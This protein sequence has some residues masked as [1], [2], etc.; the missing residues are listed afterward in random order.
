MWRI[1]ATPDIAKASG[2]RDR[3]ILELFYS[4]GI[5]RMEL[6]RLDVNDLNL[7]DNSVLIRH[8]KANR[9]RIVPLGPRATKWLARYVDECRQSLA[10]SGDCTLFVTNEGKP[11]V[12]N[13]LGD[14]VKGYL[15]KA[16]FQSKGACHLF[17][18]SCATHMLENGADIRY[19]QELL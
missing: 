19:I 17:R 18:H 2:I 6:A 14:L 7:A 15:R 11:F 1:M 4:T 8:G 16:G 5:R 9:D 13:R 3:A 12:K 10:T